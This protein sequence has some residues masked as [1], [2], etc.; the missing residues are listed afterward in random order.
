[1]VLVILMDMIKDFA[2]SLNNN[3]NLTINEKR[4]IVDFISDLNKLQTKIEGID[5]T[6]LLNNLKDLKI[7]NVTLEN[8]PGYS[9]KDNTIYL[10]NET[11][12]ER[13]KVNL[14]KSLLQC[15][16][17]NRNGNKIKYGVLDPKGGNYALNEAITQRFLD[18]MLGNSENNKLDFEMN[19]YAKI[20]ELIGLDKIFS[21]YFKADY[22]SL[23][24]DFANYKI[25]LPLLSQKYDR[26][27]DLNLN[28]RDISIG[29]ERIISDVERLLMNAYAQKMLNEGIDK[30]S[31]ERFKD[32]IITPETATIYEKFNKEI[33]DGLNS[34][35]I[36]FNMLLSGVNMSKNSSKIM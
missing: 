8:K 16:I 1:M 4:F 32:N 12:N 3:Q 6:N 35:N 31:V 15:S 20:Q 18:L 30:K 23:A 10:N 25:A 11:I 34:N 27:M 5:Y 26:I 29:D 33:Y 2:N 36:Y 17:T 19:I 24:L 14:Y 9:I 21:S 28:N 22:E 7:N 13:W